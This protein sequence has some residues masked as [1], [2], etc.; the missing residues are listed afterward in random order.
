MR[1]DNIDDIVNNV[2][3]HQTIVSYNFNASGPFTVHDGDLAYSSGSTSNWVTLMYAWRMPHMGGQDY[4][5]YSYA[6]YVWKR[7]A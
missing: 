7:T 1:T 6:C 4:Y 2:S 3:K 5:Q